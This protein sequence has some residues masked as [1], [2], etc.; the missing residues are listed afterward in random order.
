MR[1]IEAAAAAN[2]KTLG[3]ARSA[4]RPSMAECEGRVRKKNVFSFSRRF[5]AESFTHGNVATAD[6]ATPNK[7]K[8]HRSIYKKLFDLIFPDDART[9]PCARVSKWFILLLFFWSAFR[10]ISRENNF[11]IQMFLFI[12]V[13]IAYGFSSITATRRSERR[14]KK[15]TRTE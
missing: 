6:T 7:P 8:R 15:K 14:K 1:R 3:Y 5:T 12:S 4:S 10:I 9:R 13:G 2:L 11:Q